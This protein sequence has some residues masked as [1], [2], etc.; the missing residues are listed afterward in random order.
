MT[1]LD[2]FKAFFDSMGVE[3]SIFPPREIPHPDFPDDNDWCLFVSQA[4]F[5]FNTEQV[6][7]SIHDDEMGGIYPRII[8]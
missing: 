6:F 5:H 8:K 3:Y 2:K 1:D 4:I 7:I